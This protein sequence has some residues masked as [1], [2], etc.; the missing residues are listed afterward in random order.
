MIYTVRVMDRQST[1]VLK[2]LTKNVVKDHSKIWK[3]VEEGGP[4]G[5]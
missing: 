5:I 1:N 4:R 2:K 3:S